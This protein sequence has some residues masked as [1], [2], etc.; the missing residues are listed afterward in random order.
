VLFRAQLPRNAMGKI[1]KP[2][3]LAELSKLG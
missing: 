2:V 3:L 1:V